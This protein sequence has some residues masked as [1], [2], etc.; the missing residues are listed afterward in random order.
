MEKKTK[1]SVGVIEKLFTR[2]PS[3]IR[4]MYNIKMQKWNDTMLI[5]YPSFIAITDSDLDIK[6]Y[7]KGLSMEVDDYVYIALN[8]ISIV[9]DDQKVDMQIILH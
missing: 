3:D 1:S 5:T 9:L 2:I 4:K 8:H 6:R 7:D